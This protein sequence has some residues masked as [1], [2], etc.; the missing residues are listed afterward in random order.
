MALCNTNGGPTNDSS[1]QGGLLSPRAE[2]KL[3]LTCNWG[4]WEHCGQAQPQQ[5]QWRGAQTI[6]EAHAGASVFEQL[7]RIRWTFEDTQFGL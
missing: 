7:C 6:R 3:A 2:K 4:L 1:V 5:A